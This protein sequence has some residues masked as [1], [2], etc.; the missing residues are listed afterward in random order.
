MSSCSMGSPHHPNRFGLSWFA[1][2]MFD[3]RRYENPRE[4][5]KDPIQ[6]TWMDTRSLNLGLNRLVAVVDLATVVK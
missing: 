1:A 5:A 2:G 3:R 6:T 4:S